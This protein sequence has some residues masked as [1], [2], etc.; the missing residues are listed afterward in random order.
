[1]NLSETQLPVLSIRILL[2][3]AAFQLVAQAQGPA[4]DIAIEVD[5]VARTANVS[6]KFAGGHRTSNPLNLSFAREVAGRSDLGARISGIVLQNQDG[7]N[8]A[9]RKLQNSEYLAEGAFVSWSYSVDLTPAA[10]RIALAHSSWIGE[11]DGILMLGDLVPQVSRERASA[12]ISLNLPDGWHS[13]SAE[14]A[15]STDDLSDSVIFIG[16][17]GSAVDAKAE[18]GDLQLL[19]TGDFHFT[20]EE[21]SAMV[22]EIFDEYSKMLGNLPK[23]PYLIAV[24]RF[25]GQAPHGQWEAETR[26]RTVTI[27]SS[28]MPFRTQSLQRLHE[29]LRHEI[30]HLWLPNS[31][32]LIGNY[33]WFYEGFAMYMSLK[34][35]V[36]L[37]RIRFDDFL[38]TLGRAHT[39]DSNS[40][41]RRPLTDPGVDPTVRYARGMIVA[42]LTDLDLLR[43]SNGKSDVGHVLRK[44]VAD[45]SGLA[46]SLLA[47]EAVKPM[48]PT[49]LFKRNVE[50]SDEVEWT[51]DLASA[52][53]ESKQTGRTTTLSV[54]TKL[55]GQQKAILDRLG[56]NNWRRAGNRK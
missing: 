24:K 27:M 53:I 1:M 37:N 46:R 34:L 12:S 51:A 54:A 15:V 40:K 39:I 21:A 43:N 9:V 47:I 45:P 30:F 50:G 32:E 13:I 16:K 35:A 10:N 33:A 17:S 26:G 44:L 42:F 29:Q 14:R 25:P 49:S 5:A 3:F 7:A 19:I 38:D 36:K 48:F 22:R 8:V 31:V 52:G 2:F 56:Y 55:R 41:P 20:P 23:R 11:S 28:D 4:V 6:G 18:A